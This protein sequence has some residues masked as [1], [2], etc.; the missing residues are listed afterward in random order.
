MTAEGR[1]SPRLQHGLHWTSYTQVSRLEATAPLRLQAV[2]RAL[3]WLAAND[4]RASGAA[5]AALAV[6]RPSRSCLF[7]QARL[8]CAE[9]L[10]TG[11]PTDGPGRQ[12]GD[13]PTVRR[14]ARRLPDFHGGAA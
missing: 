1:R 3:V 13:F 11:L 2:A 10:A 8:V 6:Q 5:R 14:S 12:L 4:R 7:A 9:M